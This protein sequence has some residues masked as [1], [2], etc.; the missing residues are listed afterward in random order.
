MPYFCVKNNWKLKLVSLIIF[1]VSHY[2]MQLNHWVMELN[3]RAFFVNNIHKYRFT[4]KYI[5]SLY[6]TWGALLI[7]TE[8]SDCTYSLKDSF[9][10]NLHKAPH[11][12]WDFTR[13]PQN[14]SVL[15]FS[16]TLKIASKI[17]IGTNIKYAQGWGVAK[18]M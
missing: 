18:Y 13:W 8:R 17:S 6:Q 1:P 12:I 3:S 15:Q 11:T 5:W 10:F 2:T 16:V 9:C 7:F 4:E 14:I